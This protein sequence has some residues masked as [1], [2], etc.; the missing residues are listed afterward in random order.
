[1]KAHA[2]KICSILRDAGFEALFAGGCVRDIL[3]GIKPKDYDIATSA[4]PDQVAKVFPDCKPVGAAF[5]VQLVH[6]HGFQYEIATFRSDGTY[7][8]GRRPD[9]VDFCDAEHDAE[10]RDFTVNAL[11]MNPETEDVID[12]VDGQA[13]L[14]RRCLRAVGDA[15]TRF[16][17]DH[18]RLLRAVRF[19]SQL[20]FEIVPDTYEAIRISAPLLQ[21]ISP[22]R[23]RNELERILTQPRA[24][25]AFRILKDT[26]LLDV[27][28][29]E[30]L[31]MNGCDQPPEYHPE[32]DVWIHTLLLLDHL[33][34]PT[35]TL[36]MGALLHD[37]GKPATQTFEDRIRFNQHEK[38][39]ARTTQDICKRLRLSNEETERIVWLVAQ[40][41]RIAVTPDMKES[42][43]KRLVR[44]DGFAELLE[45]M[46]VDCMA[47]H[48]DLSAYDW[49]KDYAENI[50]EEA[51]RPKPLINGQDL[52]VLGYAPG[53]MF[54]EILTAVEDAQLEGEIDTRD[55][56]LERV[57]SDWPIKPQ[58]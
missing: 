43:R 39:G 44:E 11:F 46:R 12:Y 6:R 57:K 18:L 26:E 14:K 47:S 27:F 10:R 17:E 42:K 33:K 30:L 22:E 34:S 13:D 45:L 21:K 50:P 16:K 51:V 41:M 20:D 7:S 8:D 29:P 55:A 3:L 49:I 38:V 40:H 23:I 54:K 28:L 53:P 5:G 15:E 25:D 52:I 1:M 24:S 58:A 2:K 4:T 9:Q 19:A 37:V 48:A 36:A 56:A 31:P 35:F 32:G